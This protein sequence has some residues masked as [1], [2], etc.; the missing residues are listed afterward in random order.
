MEPGDGRWTGE[1]AINEESNV[2]NPCQ[3]SYPGKVCAKKGLDAAASPR[4]SAQPALQ[5]GISKSAAAASAGGEDANTVP[6]VV[7]ALGPDGGS[8]TRS[9]VSHLGISLSLSPLDQVHGTNQDDQRATTAL[10]GRQPSE[11]SDITERQAS[12]QLSQ[13]FARPRAGS[14]FTGPIPRR[15]STGGS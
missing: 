2:P 15:R 14:H 10:Q 4:R 1:Q 12:R 3:G 9:R 8:V 7:V 5:S 11:D 13:Q 6:L